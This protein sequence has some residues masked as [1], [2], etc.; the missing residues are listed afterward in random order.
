MKINNRGYLKNNCYGLRM[1]NL[2]GSLMQKIKFERLKLISPKQYI[3]PIISLNKENGTY[4]LIDEDYLRI[5][6]NHRPYKIILDYV[7]KNAAIAIKNKID[8][9]QRDLLKNTKC[10]T[11]IF[12]AQSKYFLI[13]D[14]DIGISH[15]SLKNAFN[16]IKESKIIKTDLNML[17]KGVFEFNSSGDIGIAVATFQDPFPGLVHNTG[18]VKRSFF[19]LG[20]GLRT[21]GCSER[22]FVCDLAAPTGLLQRFLK[23]NGIQN[24][25]DVLKKFAPREP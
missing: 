21:L 19:D 3:P 7:I 23:N 17:M 22:T 9:K 24:L 15:R 16:I 14:I 25:G 6:H 12:D 5:N 13:S 8:F 11:Y 10:F 20:L 1:E 4:L 18:L 2:V